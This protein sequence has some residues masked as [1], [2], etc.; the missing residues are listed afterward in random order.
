MSKTVVVWEWLAQSVL[1]LTVLLQQHLAEG[2]L[3]APANRA[4]AAN[5][6]AAVGVTAVWTRDLVLGA[7]IKT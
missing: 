6:S 2:T 5:V 4:D 1:V 3:S 7:H